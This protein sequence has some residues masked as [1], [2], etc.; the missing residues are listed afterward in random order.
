MPA[1]NV[2]LFQGKSLAEWGRYLGVS[3]ECVRL[4]MNRY[5]NPY[6]SHKTIAKNYHV[7]SSWNP[8]GVFANTDE[9]KIILEMIKWKG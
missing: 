7:S 4:R 8:D 6:G 2:R 1:N 3:R 9:L 5:N